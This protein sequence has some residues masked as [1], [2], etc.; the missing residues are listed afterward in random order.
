MNSFEPGT[1]S[2]LQRATGRA[3]ARC[4][5]AAPARTRGRS[6]SALAA[7]EEPDEPHQRRAPAPARAAAG[8]GSSGPGA[9]SRRRSSPGRARTSRCEASSSRD[10]PPERVPG[11]DLRARGGREQ[12]AR[13]DDAVLDELVSGNLHRLQ[14][15]PFGRAARR[16]RAPRRGFPRPGTR[17]RARSG[18]GNCID[19]CQIRDPDRPVLAPDAQVHVDDV[20]VGDREPAK[21]VRD[22]ERALLVGRPVVPDDPEPVVDAGDAEAV[23]EGRSRRAPCSRPA[24]TRCR[25]R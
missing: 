11:P 8:A 2:W 17:A 14:R 12:A 9:P 16:L 25:P 6:P 7:V 1:V 3:P 21:A 5:S 19:R 18:R 10:D 24:G 20:V 15:R 23:R 4:P 13:E 22:R